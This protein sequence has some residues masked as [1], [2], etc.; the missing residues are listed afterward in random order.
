MQSPKYTVIQIA[1]NSKKYLNDLL[2]ATAIKCAAKLE[3]NPAVRDWNPALRAYLQMANAGADANVHAGQSATLPPWMQPAAT[4]LD[5][6]I[7]VLFHKM[8]TNSQFLK[9]YEESKT[10]QNGRLP[11]VVFGKLKNYSGNANFDGLLESASERFRVKLFNSKLFEVKDDGVLV[12]LAQR[13]VANGKSPL[14]DG[15][16]MEVLKQHGS[17][18]YF[19]SGDFKLLTDDLDGISYYK[20]HLALHSLSTGKIVWEEIETFEVKR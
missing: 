4:S 19:V 18:D 3:A 1:H 16:L 15:K 5:R 8:F 13:I 6:K 9:N 20:L 10:Q 7:D 14:E 2:Q 12:E 11:V 17:P